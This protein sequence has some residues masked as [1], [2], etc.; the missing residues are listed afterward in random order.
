MKTFITGKDVALEDTIHSFQQ[1]L[2]NHNLEIN[3][4]SWF[5]PIPNVWSVHIQNKQCPMLFTNGK[6]AT[7]K[8]A[9][10]SALGEYFERLATNYF[11]SDYYLGKTTSQSD[12]VHYPCEKWFAIPEDNQLPKGLLSKELWIFY[13]PNQELLASDLVDLQSSHRERG[14]CALPF[15]LQSN[16]QTIY[17]PVNLIANLYASN[18]M[19]AGNT[20]NE[21]RVQALSEIFE[22]YVKNYII[23]NAVS[24]PEIPSAIISRYPHIQEAINALEEEGFPI[25]CFDASLGGQ[26]PVICVVLFNP[27]NGTSYASFGAH[28]N[29]A[30]AFERTVTELLQGRNL[31]DLDV[32]SPPSFNNDEVAELSNLETHFIDSSGVI[33]WDLFNQTP[34]YEF[35]NWDFSGT[36][37]QEFSNL[38]AIMQSKEVPVLI[39]DYTHLG[40]YACRII[41]VGMSE[42]YP[43]EDLI[44][45]NNNMAIDWR[46][47]ILSLPNSQYE[48]DEYLALIEQLDNDGFDDSARVREL[49]G[50]ATGNNNA[51]FTLRVGELKAMLALAGNDLGQAK[52]W[53]DWSIEMNQSIFSP[54]RL[55]AYRCLQT[56][57]DFALMRDEDQINNYL[58]TFYKMY[59][60]ECVN[61]MWQYVTGDK[62]FFG[63]FEVDEN[64]SQFETHQALLNIY[65]K[66][67]NLHNTKN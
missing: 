16:G 3:E 21:A 8:A 48:L 62:T 59:G 51:W 27:Q 28:P 10:A 61:E 60:E 42:I 37:K 31:K 6:G 13:N 11:F 15:T 7:K 36:T 63:L 23:A 25:Y 50:L 17:V 46:D 1:L 34:D 4:A 56:L 35:V 30:V 14:I 38:I 24:L 18:G 44:I 32:F 22:R 9:L 49:L 47:V 64:L 26:Y 55:H 43:P 65:T 2:A 40:V 19:S 54:T 33:S 66:L 67:C 29:F 52:E 39:M 45:A 57:I 12:F 20:Q 53:V 41:A 5:N 58:N